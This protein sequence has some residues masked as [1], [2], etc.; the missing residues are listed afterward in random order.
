M[1]VYC[2]TKK[3]RAEQRKNEAVSGHAQVRCNLRRARVHQL[4]REVGRFRRIVLWSHRMWPHVTLPMRGAWCDAWLRLVGLRGGFLKLCVQ[5]RG[6]HVHVDVFVEAGTAVLHGIV[7]QPVWM[8]QGE[9]GGA[10]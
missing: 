10:T 1:T 5:V 3:V 9:G 7:S 8:I 2:V 6:L 4:V